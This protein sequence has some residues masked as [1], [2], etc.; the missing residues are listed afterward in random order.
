M[1]DLH[2][3]WADLSSSR[4]IRTRLCLH[5]GHNHICRLSARHQPDTCFICCRGAPMDWYYLPRMAP[6]KNTGGKMTINL[7]ADQ[8]SYLII[9]LERE[10]L[11]LTKLAMWRTE[12][13]EIIGANETLE[14]I[15]K[16][17]CNEQKKICE[18]SRKAPS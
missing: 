13:P 18:S 16:V 17:L 9:I 12:T 15:K 2:Q 11:F 6:S 1:D 4:L 7:T 5:L 14:E 10:K 3:A 8:L